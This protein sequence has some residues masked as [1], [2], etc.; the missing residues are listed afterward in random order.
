MKSIKLIAAFVAAAFA[1]QAHAFQITSLAPQG[2]VSSVRQVVVKFDE[3]AANFG[4]PKAKSP[5]SLSCSDAQATKV[6]AAGS[7]TGNGPSSL[8]STCRQGLHAT[9][10]S[11][12]A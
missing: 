7:A 10:R 9:Y 2:E 12:P 3:R 11:V 5:L 6:T 4:D 1:L 8:T